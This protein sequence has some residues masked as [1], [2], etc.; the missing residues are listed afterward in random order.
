ML[1]AYKVIKSIELS[2]HNKEKIDY[3][4]HLLEGDTF[5]IE[6]GFWSTNYAS[7]AEEVFILRRVIYSEYNLYKDESGELISKECVKDVDNINIINPTIKSYDGDG[8]RTIGTF[9][10]KKP[11]IE[12][13]DIL[14]SEG[15]I[16]ESVSWNRELKLKQIINEI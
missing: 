2:F 10:D 9:F 12:K 5:F 8:V 11:F 1:I 16:E 15:I 6:G 13:I 3:G 7:K 4:I 14:I